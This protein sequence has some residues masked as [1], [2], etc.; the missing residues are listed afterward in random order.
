[1]VKLVKRCLKK[2]AANA[3]LSFEELDTILIEIEGIINSPPLTYVDVD[4]LDEPLTPSSLVSG[5]RL[6][7]KTPFDPSLSLDGFYEDFVID[8]GKLPKVIIAAFLG[9]ISALKLTRT[10]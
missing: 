4:S 2:I 7:T 8:Q 5:R 6:L 3:H 1:M 10:P 9:K